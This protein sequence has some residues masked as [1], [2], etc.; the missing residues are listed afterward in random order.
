VIVI[1]D[2]PLIGDLVVG[3][4]MMTS[5]SYRLV[6]RW[7]LWRFARGWNVIYALDGSLRID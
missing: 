2:E 5:L 7:R 3:L 6:T 1:E 4:L